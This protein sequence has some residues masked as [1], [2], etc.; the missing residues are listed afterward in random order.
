[1]SSS[2]HG[3]PS[4]VAI[5]G[6]HGLSAS[7]RALRQLPVDPVA[8]VSVADDGGSTGRLRAASERIA[9]GDLRKSLVALADTEGPL[10]DVMEHRFVSGELEGHS[11]G[12]LMLAAFEEST[13][14][15]MGALDQMS[16]LL[17]VR[18]R[19]LPASIDPV[20]LVAELEDGTVMV[21]Q[22]LISSTSGISMVSLDPK[23]VACGEVPQVISD[24]RAV[25]LGPGSLYT[26][27]LASAA[28]PDV[29]DALVS[30]RAPV[31]Y[32]CNLGPQR[33]ETDGYDVSGHVEALYRHGLEP[34]IVLYDPDRIGGADGVAGAQPA[35]MAAEGTRAHDPELLA[36]ALSA[37]LSL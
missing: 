28:L 32:V 8:V 35:Q 30:T 27:V 23:P 15:V 1:M 13:G 5:G 26:S 34:D 20:E 22:E 21:G 4:V 10:L 3:L 33:H 24:A 16:K 14:S 18:G 17:Q 37:A 11:F 31:A 19:V 25:V 9:P 6:G 36:K 7:L 29:R 12:N 2:S